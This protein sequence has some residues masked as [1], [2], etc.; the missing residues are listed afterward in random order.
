MSGA[1]NSTVFTD[2]SL[3]ARTVNVFGNAK[4]TT[5]TGV[6]AGTFDADGDFL[7]MLVTSPGTGDFTLE[8]YIRPQFVPDQSEAFHAIMSFVGDTDYAGTLYWQ[9][10]A[11]FFEGLTGQYGRTALG[12]SVSTTQYTHIEACRASGILRLFV[13]GAQ[14]LEGSTPAQYSLSDNY[15]SGILRFGRPGV[16]GDY[17]NG[18]M[19]WAR[20]TR[21]ARHTTGFT[22]PAIPYI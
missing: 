11:I 7:Q 3:F 22:P 20:Y 4:I 15:N 17:Y 9:A 12:G 5:S 6:E 16:D 13:G 19:R 21:A 14:L 10:G 8:A 1:N 18:F 2:L